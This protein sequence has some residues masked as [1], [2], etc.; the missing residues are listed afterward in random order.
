MWIKLMKAG[1]ALGCHQMA[2][3]SFFIKDYQFPV[4]ARCTGVLAGYLIFLITVWFFVLPL[5]VNISFMLIMLID[6][7]IQHFK[8]RESTNIRRFISGALCGYGMWA[9]I[10]I[11]IVYLIK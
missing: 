9:I 4:C 6:W 5:Y 10:K 11:S 7:L 1:N 8:W 2:D 3:R